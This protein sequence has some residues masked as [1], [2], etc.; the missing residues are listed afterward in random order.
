ME[1]IM[2]N[3][4]RLMLNI[5]TP[6]YFDKKSLSRCCKRLFYQNTEGVLLGNSLAKQLIVNTSQLGASLKLAPSLKLSNLFPRMIRPF[7][8]FHN[9]FF[10]KQH[11]FKLTFGVH[12]QLV[13]EMLR[14]WVAAFPTCQ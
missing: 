13:V 12:R 2:V 5:K 6:Q 8:I 4:E 9:I 1:K 3:G 11:V 10:V 14:T 7:H